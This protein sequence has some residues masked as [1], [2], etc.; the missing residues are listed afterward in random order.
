MEA[1]A[2]ANGM[3]KAVAAAVT[4]HLNCVAICYKVFHSPFSPIQ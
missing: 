4:T 3:M 1:G 2:V